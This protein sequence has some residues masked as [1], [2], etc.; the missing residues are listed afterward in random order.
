MVK[1]ILQNVCWVMNTSKKV[2]RKTEILIQ[3][4]LSKCN[5]DN[6]KNIDGVNSFQFS[7]GSVTV[8]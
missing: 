5:L 8:L 7:K 2:G 6:Q 3:K 4:K 1:T